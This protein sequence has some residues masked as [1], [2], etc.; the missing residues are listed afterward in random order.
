MPFD[1]EKQNLEN[2]VYYNASKLKLVQRGWNPTKL[3]TIPERKR[4]QNAGILV[5]GLWNTK[6]MLSSEA[7][8]LLNEIFNNSDERT[9]KKES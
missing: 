1:L 7:E 3:F 5:R 6:M 9:T 2:M 4:F 8:G